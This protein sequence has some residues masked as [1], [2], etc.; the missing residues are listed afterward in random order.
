L[1]QVQC[2]HRDL[3]ILQA[4]GRDFTTFAI[5]DKPVGAV[6]V[7]NDIETFVDFLPQ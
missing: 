7:L 5:K 4:I 2:K 3:L 1:E 6:P